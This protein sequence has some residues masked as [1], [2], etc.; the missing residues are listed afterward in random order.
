MKGKAAHTTGCVIAVSMHNRKCAAPNISSWFMY[1]WF[2]Q[3]LNRGEGTVPEITCDKSKASLI[4]YY[5]KPLVL[6]GES[7]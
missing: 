7:F 4:L 2:S 1:T 3:F 5:S 6:H